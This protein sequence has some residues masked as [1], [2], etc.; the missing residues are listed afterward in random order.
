MWAKWC[1]GEARPE[2][3]DPALLARRTHARAATPSG[4]RGRPLARPPALPYDTLRSHA[5]KPEMDF[6]NFNLVQIPQFSFTLTT[7]INDLV[8]TIQ[9]RTKCTA[10]LL[11]SLLNHTNPVPPCTPGVQ[12]PR[13]QGPEGRVRNKGTERRVVGGAEESQGGHRISQR[14]LL[15][16]PV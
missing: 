2:D 16:C 8:Y 13:R 15:W 7:L 11:D 14:S 5:L 9:P 10:E 12:E 6:V 1:W 3:P 4:N